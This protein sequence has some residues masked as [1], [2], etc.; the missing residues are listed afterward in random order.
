M[1]AAGIDQ[2]N[3]VETSKAAKN[4]L[5]ELWDSSTG[6]LIDAKLQRFIVDADKYKEPYQYTYLYRQQEVPS[7]LKDKENK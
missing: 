1:K 6:E 4:R 5:I 7:H 3:T 2:L